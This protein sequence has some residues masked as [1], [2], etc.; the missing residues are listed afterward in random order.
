MLCA[1]VLGALAALATR[2][3]AQV[4]SHDTLASARAWAR[5][6]NQRVLLLLTGGAVAIEDA[7]EAALRQ[8]YGRLLR[9]EYQLAALPKDSVPGTALHRRLGLGEV[10]LPALVVL[11]TADAVL[12][13]LDSGQ[14]LENG[15]FA[16]TRVGAFLQPHAC[17]PREVR[18]VLA[19]GLA[20]A[21]ES[22]RQVFVYL[23]APT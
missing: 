11:D 19:A 8:Q 6:E 2:A 17:A 23:S 16:P 12:G 5:H 22:E 3:P 9:Y 1:V 13:K 18:K 15:V 21:K 20:V 7:L 4:Q 10:D 14:M